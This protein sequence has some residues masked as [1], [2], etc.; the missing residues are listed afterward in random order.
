MVA[1]KINNY[2]LIMVGL[3]GENDG[4]HM[5]NENRQLASENERLISL[6]QSNKKS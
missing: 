3:T 1:W 6:L 5:N 4:V 2:K